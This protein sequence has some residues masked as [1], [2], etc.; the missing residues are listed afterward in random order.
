[1]EEN[2][3]SISLR[4]N[5]V[6]I[7]LF[8]VV[9]LI[10]AACASNSQEILHQNVKDQNITQL[11]ENIGRGLNINE[12]DRYGFTPL[13]LA[14]YYGYGPLVKFLCEKGAN[15]NAQDN[16]GNSAL[17]YAADNGYVDTFNILMDSGAD[18]NLVNKQG[19]NALWCAK[20]NKR[21]AMILKLEKAMTK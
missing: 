10:C 3:V 16:E 9:T 15:I 12:R 14:A 2:M 7:A 19:H 4:S 18:V 8:T 5:V 20:N 6:K 21:E 17:I 11:E 13:I 1:M